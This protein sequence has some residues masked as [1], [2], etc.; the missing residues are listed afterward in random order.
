MI[1]SL[2]ES[3]ENAVQLLCT[4]PGIDCNSAITS[5]KRAIIAVVRMILTAVYHMLPTGEAWNPIDLYKQKE[6][7]AKQAMKLL[8][9]DPAKSTLFQIVIF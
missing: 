5:I 6:K 9:T 7:S 2:V 1:D 3:Y 4:I 8:I